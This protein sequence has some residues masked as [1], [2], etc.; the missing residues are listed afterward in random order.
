ME[1]NNVMTK[2]QLQEDYSNVYVK[3]VHL[4]GRATMAIAFI[5]M[6]APV[7]YMHFVAGFT[8]PA[9]AYMACAAAAC[10]AG[11][12]GWIAEPISY[13]PIL[14]A[15]GTYMSYLAGNVGNTRVPVAVAVQSATDSDNSSP[16]G[17]MATVIGVG[18]S[19]FFSLIVLTVI[20]LVGSAMLQVVPEPVLKALGYVLPCLYGSMLT[21]RLMANF[22]GS[23]KYVPPGICGIPGLQIYRIYQVRSA[24]GHSRNLYLC[25]H[26]APVRGRKELSHPTAKGMG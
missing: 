6:F 10:A 21:M 13:F 22:K 20:I 18:M 11:V 24:D 25:I 17:Q 8:A 23:I 16:R 19:I 4:I 5:L 12:G 3:K 14:G 2:E 7:L 26:P 9:D 15:A 1:E